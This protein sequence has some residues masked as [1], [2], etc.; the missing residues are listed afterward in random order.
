MVIEVDVKID[1]EDMNALDYWTEK[2]ETLFNFGVEKVVWIFS[3]D[4][5]IILAE[6]NKDWIEGNW[7]YDF[8]LMPNHIINI[9]K[10]IEKKKYIVGT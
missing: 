4:R 9:Q 7:T 10:M 5:K 2:T 3:E 1:V 8:E 6:P